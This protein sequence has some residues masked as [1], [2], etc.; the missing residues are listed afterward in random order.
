VID[1]WDQD[2]PIQVSS[3]DLRTAPPT[4]RLTAVKTARRFPRFL[5]SVLPFSFRSCYGNAQQNY[6]PR[7]GDAAVAMQRDKIKIKR[8]RCSGE[9][10]AGVHCDDTR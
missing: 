7:C 6:R 2:V 8:D 3:R 10:Y 9:R 1:A 4:L 5:S